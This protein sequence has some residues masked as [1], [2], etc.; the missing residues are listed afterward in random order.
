MYSSAHLESL[1]GGFTSLAVSAI[2]RSTEPETSI[3]KKQNSCK[4]KSKY[5]VVSST[6]FIY[7]QILLNFLYSIYFYNG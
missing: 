5:N 4:Q 2:F 3:N 7:S 6:L 1:F